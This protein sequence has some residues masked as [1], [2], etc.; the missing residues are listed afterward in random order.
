MHLNREVPDVRRAQ[1]PGDKPVR[2]DYVEIVMRLE[3]RE[4]HAFQRDRIVSG[5]ICDDRVETYLLHAGH[6][7]LYSREQ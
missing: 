6:K 4:G 1:V 3:L 2:L 5:I 7:R